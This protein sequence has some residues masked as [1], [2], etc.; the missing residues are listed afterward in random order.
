MM[1]MQAR[2]CG[3]RSETVEVTPSANTGIDQGSRM[4]QS[5]PPRRHRE[6]KL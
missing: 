5:R 3:L 6:Y 4:R 2:P 1:R